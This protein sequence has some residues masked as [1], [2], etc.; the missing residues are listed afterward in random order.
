MLRV[1]HITTAPQSQQSYY[2]PPDPEDF[3]ISDSFQALLSD[4]LSDSADQITSKTA[5][6]YTPASLPSPGTQIWLCLLWKNFKIFLAFFQTCTSRL[7]LILV[8]FEHIRIFSTSQFHATHHGGR[9]TAVKAFQAL[10]T[11]YKEVSVTW[12]GDQPINMV[13][14]I[15]GRSLLQN[16]QRNECIL[17]QG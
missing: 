9:Q 14:L 17:S 4:L 1:Q 5:A 15:W 10:V 6:A 12:L 11:A 2:P 7:A 13:M 3:T 8:R 16:S